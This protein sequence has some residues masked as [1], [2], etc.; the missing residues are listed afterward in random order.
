MQAADLEESID[1]TWVLSAQSPVQQELLERH[2]RD[3][4]VFV[5]G[6]FRVWLRGAAVNY[7]VLR[8]DPRPEPAPVPSDPD[9]NTVKPNQSAFR[10]TALEIL[11][12]LAE[13]LTS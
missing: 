6:A 13:L 3:K 5:E 4:P 10:K 11:P 12:K 9:G 2:S 8:A 1:K 7:F